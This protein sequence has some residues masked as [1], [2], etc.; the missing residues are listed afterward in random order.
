MQQFHFPYKWYLKDGYPKEKIGSYPFDYNF[1]NNTPQY[2]VGMSVPPIMAAQ[3]SK[4]IQVQW[5]DN[6]N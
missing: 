1:L 5:L 6:I 3:I 4:Q 2:L